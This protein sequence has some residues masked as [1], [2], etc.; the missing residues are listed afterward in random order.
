MTSY[1]KLFSSYISL[2]NIYY[3]NVV[4]GSHTCVVGSGNIDRQPSFKLKNVLQ[5]REFSRNFI[6]I[7][8]LTRDQNFAVTFFPSHCVFWDLTMVRT[9]TVDKE[10][11]V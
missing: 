6:F 9:T 5:I 8:K 7:H 1:S 3:I 4:D 10:Q 2:S 11:G